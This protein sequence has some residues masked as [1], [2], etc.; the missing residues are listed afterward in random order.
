MKTRT[1]TRRGCLDKPLPA[2]MSIAMWSWARCA[3]VQAQV[4]LW[5]RATLPSALR[6]CAALCLQGLGDAAECVACVCC[7]VPA[8]ASPLVPKQGGCL[9]LFQR[10]ST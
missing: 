8:G 9:Y 10:S 2:P 3:L 7:P 1:P 5:R 4:A 6:A